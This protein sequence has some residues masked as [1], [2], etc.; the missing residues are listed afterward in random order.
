M[1]AYNEGEHIETCVREWYDTVITKVPDSELIVVDDRSKDNTWAVM[2]RL[3][4]ELP[5]FK[6]VQT[7]KNGGHGKAVRFGLL[8]ARGE[9]VFQ[10]DSDRQHK[11]EDFGRLWA[12][13][14]EADFV[15]GVRESRADGPVRVVVTRVMRVLNFLVWQLWIRDANCPFK[16]MRRSAL[17][18]LLPQIPEDSFI[19]MVMLSILARHQR[20]RIEEELVRHLPRTAGEQSLK[21]M[22]KWIR[23]GG[24]CAMQLVSFRFGILRRRGGG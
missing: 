18:Q 11:P 16:L 22:T 13:R 17:E 14:N 19:P 6:P 2:Q 3:S 12:H 9:F 7:P 5:Q 15:L 23:V 21:G 8:Q 1:P 20:Y 4:A 10:T 24:K